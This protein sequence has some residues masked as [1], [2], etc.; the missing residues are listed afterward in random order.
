MLRLNGYYPP[1]RFRAALDYV[2]G[3]HE[4][5]IAFADVPRAARARAGERPAARRA[6]L[7]EAALSPRRLA[8]ARGES[9]SSCSSSRS[10]ARRATELHERGLRDAAVRDLIGKFDVARLELFG[11]AAVET[12]EAGRSP[13]RSGAA[14]SGSPIRRASS[15]STRRAG[16][17]SGWRPSSSR[18]TSRP[19][20]STWQAGRISRSRASS[21][22]CRAR[23]ERIRSAGGSV[24]VVAG[25]ELRPT[26]DVVR[27]W[28][29]LTSWRFSLLQQS[30]DALH[31]RRNRRLPRLLQRQP[32]EPR[33]RGMRQPACRPSA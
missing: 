13:R 24:G 9:R 3:K 15:S 25:Q 21:A 5:R 23:A 22:T 27:S 8:A 17:Y 2:A 16:R 18:S 10:S 31:R 12:P 4:G 20:S 26:I 7:H 11:A 14:R 28:R 6:V 32:D 29:A 33:L 19:A 30:E 1:H